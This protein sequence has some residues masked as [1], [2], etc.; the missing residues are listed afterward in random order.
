MAGRLWLFIISLRYV[1]KEDLTSFDCRSQIIPWKWLCF[2]LDV[3]RKKQNGLVFIIWYLSYKILE[4]EKG[5]IS[6]S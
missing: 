3:W 1:R 4:W 6:S 5:I 2:N